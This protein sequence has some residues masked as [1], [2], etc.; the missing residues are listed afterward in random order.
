MRFAILDLVQVLQSL[1]C[2]LHQ[3]ACSHRLYAKRAAFAAKWMRHK[4]I[5]IDNDMAPGRALAKL[6]E[7]AIPRVRLANGGF[8]FTGLAIY[9]THKPGKMAPAPLTV[10]MPVPAE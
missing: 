6:F 7:A 2:A 8:I 1:L 3:F 5:V 10:P 4:L 9:L